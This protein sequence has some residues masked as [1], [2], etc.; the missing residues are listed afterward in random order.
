MTTTSPLQP[1]NWKLRVRALVRGGLRVR[2]A[3]GETLAGLPPPQAIMQADGITA[4]RRRTN[5]KYVP[6]GDGSSVAIMLGLVR[7]SGHRLP[8]RFLDKAQK[9]RGRMRAP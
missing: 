1:T 7:S 9:S 5:R 2:A 3:V 6:V 8:T 4:R